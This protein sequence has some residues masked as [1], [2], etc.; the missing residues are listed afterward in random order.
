MSH[1]GSGRC[2]TYHG[3]VREMSGNFAVF[4]KWSACDMGVETFD[5]SEYHAIAVCV[6]HRST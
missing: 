6:G 5:Y 3:I 4:G 1:Y 2:A